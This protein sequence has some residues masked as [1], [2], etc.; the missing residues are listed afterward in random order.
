[1]HHLNAFYSAL[2]CS[3]YL[4]FTITKADIFFFL[5]LD[6]EHKN[7]D[8]KLEIPGQGGYFIIFVKFISQVNATIHFIKT[9]SHFQEIVMFRRKPCIA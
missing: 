7:T 3:F 8:Y 5:D 4:T 9:A 2:L 1:M 6:L